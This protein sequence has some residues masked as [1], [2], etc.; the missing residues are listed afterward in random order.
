MTPHKP[1]LRNMTHS[2]VGNLKNLSL[3]PGLGLLGPRAH[4]ASGH[5]TLPRGTRTRNCQTQPGVLAGHW[6]PPRA[7]NTLESPRA[8]SPAWSNTPGLRGAVCRAGF[9]PGLTWPHLCEA[10]VDPFRSLSPAF[11]TYKIR[12][13]A[14][15]RL[16][17]PMRWGSVCGAHT[18]T[19][20]LFPSQPP[21]GRATRPC[22]RDNRG[23]DSD[24][25][26]QLSPNS[27]S[28]GFLRT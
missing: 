14:P 13:A 8:E 11:H 17:L 19:S 20:F 2:A 12:V 9:R 22:G 5:L 16:S 18:Q 10:P 4:Q 26:H 15:T 7:L 24:Q 1:S 3:G 21:S 27:P 23:G 6:V 25:S 28:L